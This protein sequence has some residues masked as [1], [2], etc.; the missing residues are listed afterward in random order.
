MCIRDRIE[1]AVRPLAFRSDLSV[2]EIGSLRKGLARAHRDWRLPSILDE[3]LK[4]EHARLR[5][6][7]SGGE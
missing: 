3:T 7:L 4:A 6:L 5:G 2:R 1:E